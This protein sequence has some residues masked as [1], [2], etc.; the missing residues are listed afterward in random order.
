MFL[1]PYYQAVE[2]NSSKVTVINISLDTTTAEQWAVDCKD[3]S[4]AYHINPS[5]LHTPALPFNSYPQYLPHFRSFRPHWLLQTTIKGN[6]LWDKVH[7]SDRTV[8]QHVALYMMMVYYCQGYFTIEEVQGYILGK[9]I[10]GID[11]GEKTKEV[12]DKDIYGQAPGTRRPIPYV[13]LPPLIYSTC[14]L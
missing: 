13:L 7:M 5:Q 2:Y 4:Y 6:K 12:G 8:A 3:H 14:S 1:Q 10:N 9:E 11:M